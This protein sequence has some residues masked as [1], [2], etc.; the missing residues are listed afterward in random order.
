MKTLEQTLKKWY[1]Q[2]HGIGDIALIQ[3]TEAMQEYATECAREA[4]RLASE[5]LIEWSYERH[6][7][8][9]TAREAILNESNIP[10]HI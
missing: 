6:P 7:N 8:F 4:L 1:N 9:R 10:K 3:I 2:L 5:G